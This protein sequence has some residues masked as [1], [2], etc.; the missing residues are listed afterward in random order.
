MRAHR[1]ARWLWLLLLVSCGGGGVSAASEL[2][3]DDALFDERVLHEVSIE[4]EAG[5]LPDLVPG[6]D[7][8]VPCRLVF[9]G[10]ALDDVGIRLKGGPGSLRPIEGKAGFSV[11]TNEFVS[12]QRLH[13]RSRFLLNN[14]VQDPSFHSEPLGYEIWR[15]AGHPARR[16]AHARVTFNGVVFGVYVLAE[17][18]DKDYLESRYGS[19]DGNLYEGVFGEDVTDAEALDLESGED[20][21]RSDLVALRDLLWLEPDATFL[22]RV[23]DAV[24][25]DSLLRYWAVELLVRHWDGYA[26]FPPPVCPDCGSPNNWYL[27]AAPPTGRLEWIP[28]GADQL[29][30]DPA[31]PALRPPSWRSHLAARLFG[32]EEIRARL[33]GEM[34]RILDGAWDVTSLVRRLDEGEALIRG[35]VL[36]GDREPGFSFDAHDLRLSALRTFLRERPARVRAELAAAGY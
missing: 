34:R 18:I 21:G 31:S 36:G 17:A 30:T 5:D 15:R 19:D 9:D 22:A 32:F 26:T 28:H 27:Y 16:T 14:A 25:L 23:A 12:G 20:E 1:S 24:D 10:L 4:V 35:A 13:G 3:G 2:R 6:N 11:K 33:A 7:D 29:F 8:R